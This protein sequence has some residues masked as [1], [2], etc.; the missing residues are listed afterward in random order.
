MLSSDGI[1]YADTGDLAE[2]E[3]LPGVDEQEMAD[4]RVLGHLKGDEPDVM[5]QVLAEYWSALQDE[6]S[7]SPVMKAYLA[8]LYKLA[9]EQ[10]R[11]KTA[12]DDMGEQL[13]RL[14]DSPLLS[15]ER[16]RLRDN[17]AVLTTEGWK[18]NKAYLEALSQFQSSISRL[19]KSQG[20]VDPF[21]EFNAD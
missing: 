21:D 12:I 19:T 18:L 14:G 8:G 15:N 1:N 20:T 5:V 13:A 3:G 6:A 16:A 4:A 7:C 11:I 17:M 10:G 9:G 2:F